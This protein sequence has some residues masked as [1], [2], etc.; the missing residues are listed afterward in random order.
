MI[1]T[2][3]FNEIED[4]LKLG[5]TKLNE[6][7]ETTEKRTPSIQQIED[8]IMSH[9]SIEIEVLKQP[10]RKGII[11]DATKIYCHLMYKY[12]TDN[13][14]EIADKLGY[15]SANKIS[16]LLIQCEELI[17]TNKQFN[18]NLKSIES[19]L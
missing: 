12:I 17:N 9:F 8:A 10:H 18:N 4:I 1:Q 15:K 14:S 11:K 16:P 19:K 3:K 5:L 2:S 13:K 6:L 7:K